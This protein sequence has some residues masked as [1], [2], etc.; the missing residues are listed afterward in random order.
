MGRRWRAERHAIARRP[1]TRRARGTRRAR[2]RGGATSEAGARG[3][4][5]AR[6]TSSFGTR[7]GLATEPRGADLARPRTNLPRVSKYPKVVKAG[8]GRRSW[9][10]QSLQNPE[11]RNRRRPTDRAGLPQKLLSCSLTRGGFA[12]RSLYSYTFQSR[13]VRPRLSIDDGVG[14]FLPIVRP[15][16]LRASAVWASSA[17][18]PN[19]SFRLVR[20]RRNVHPRAPSTRPSIR[21]ASDLTPSSVRGRRGIFPVGFHLLLE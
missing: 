21:C 19:R 6:A 15:T 17:S 8:A 3:E 14:R 9:S 16:T 11:P 12:T 1:R 20:R 10:R 5:R 2:R 18:S 13:V 4:A 7:G